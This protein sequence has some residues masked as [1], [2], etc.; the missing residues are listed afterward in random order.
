MLKMKWIHTLSLTQRGNGKNSEK[1]CISVETQSAVIKVLSNTHTKKKMEIMMV[2][3]CQV[4]KSEKEQL[5]Q[6]WEF[7]LP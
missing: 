2:S 7:E 5:P 1:E 6:T 4:R 3:E